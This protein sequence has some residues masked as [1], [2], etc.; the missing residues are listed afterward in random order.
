MTMQPTTSEKIFKE[1]EAALFSAMKHYVLGIP[2]TVLP[3]PK[4]KVKEAIKEYA[5]HLK[6]VHKLDPDTA[7]DLHRAFIS[8][9][10]FIP[11]EEAEFLKQYN[12]TLKTEINA[13]F[14]DKTKRSQFITNKVR[15]QEESYI[16]DYKVFFSRLMKDKKLGEEG[17]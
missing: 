10:K 12:N 13:G 17:E 9:G 8:L 1:Y 5:V 16:Q 2:E 7:R 11:A 3:H 6:A 15:I 4:Q 14:A